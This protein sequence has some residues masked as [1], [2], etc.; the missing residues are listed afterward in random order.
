MGLVGFLG[1]EDH[2]AV[3]AGLDA[4]CLCVVEYELKPSQLSETKGAKVVGSACGA[5]SVSSCVTLS[6]TKP[7]YCNQSAPT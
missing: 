4:D 2:A 5:S 3:A 1:L 6:L 7:S